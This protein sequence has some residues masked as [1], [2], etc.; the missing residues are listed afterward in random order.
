MKI[1]CVR[2]G[3]KYGPEYEEY[4]E[5]KLDDYE[6]IW[7]REAFDPRVQLQWNKMLP[8]SYDLDE[9]VCVI[10]IDVFLV[11]DYKKIFDHPISRGQF[12]AAPNWWSD[13]CRINGGF[14]KYYPVDCNYIFDEFM[15][16]PIKW[17]QH[18][19]KNG[20][21]T[22]PVNGEQFFVEMMAKEELQLNALHKAWFTRWTTEKLHEMNI[23]DNES[24]DQKLM[25]WEYDTGTKYKELS[26]NEY[27]FDGG[28]HPDIKFVHFTH[29]KNK[30][31]EWENYGDFT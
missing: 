5:R 30:P 1:F 22:G 21:T 11:N 7:I 28:F 15:A 29:S 17:Q 25:Q 10:D 31:H 24:V 18:F 4:I 13:P 8:M 27:L 20:M 6:V 26:G 16:D 14:F 9:P 19:I 2:I 23:R 12:L 3:D